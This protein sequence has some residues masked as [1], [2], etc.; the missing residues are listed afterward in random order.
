MLLKISKKSDIKTLLTNARL[1][2]LDNN[3]SNKSQ[4][5]EIKIIIS[6]LIYNIQKHTPKGYVKLEFTSNNILSIEATD[7]GEGI[8][9]INLALQDGYS[10]KGTLG[11]GFASIFRLSDEVEVETS[12]KGTTIKIKKRI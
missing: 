10:T 8:D 7:Q 3:I 1:F 5:L 9:D 12:E 11:L 2:L 6:E 4:L